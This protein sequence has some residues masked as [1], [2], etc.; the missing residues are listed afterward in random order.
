MASPSKHRVPPAIRPAST[1]A[2]ATV[3][4]PPRGPAAAAATNHELWLAVHLPRLVLDS[5][6]GLLAELPGRTPV[7][8]VDLEHDGKV[9]CACDEAAAAAGVAPGMALNSALALL[10]DLQTVPR[11][12]RREQALLESVAKLGLDLFTPRASLEPPDAVVLEVRGSLRLFGGARALCERL[13]AELQASGVTARLAL[14]PTPIASLWLARAGQEV[15]FRRPDELAGRLAPLPL[16]VTRWPERSLQ[17]LA[18]MGVRTLGECLRLPRDGFARRF[19]PGMLTMLDRALGRAPDPRAVFRTRERFATR[20]DL[21]PEIADTSRLEAAIRPLLDELCAFL[22]QRGRGITTLE[23]RLRHREAAAT[24]VRLR[25]A[26]V[27]G[28]PRRMIE[29]LHERLARAALPEPV[30]AIRLA[31]GPLVELPEAPVELFA[32]DR[33]ATGAAVPQLVER[34]RARLGVEA[35]HG[36]CLVPEHRPESAWRVSEPL[37]RSRWSGRSRFQ[38]DQST[39]APGSTNRIDPATGILR[40]LW[41]LAEPQGY[42]G[43]LVI[44][45]G[46]ERIESGWWDGRDVARDYYV[47]RDPKGVRLWVFRERRRKD[48]TAEH[49]E[50]FLHGVFG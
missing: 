20:R 46:P 16:A 12:P 30:R 9:V 17:S 1:P 23:L 38:P 47:A 4:A 18:T 40:P 3:P 19:E 41:L 42:A 6:Q 39:G 36:L 11:E 27:V 7:A 44:E 49:A 34:L 33:R 25:F 8:V 15:A 28:E 32:T 50:W 10:P 13:R 26:A 21:E 2:V 5:L 29:L 24:R 43:T 35:V 22:R 14:T 45:E 37:L 48:A 31:S